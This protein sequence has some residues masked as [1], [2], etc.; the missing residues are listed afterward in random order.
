MLHYHLTWLWYAVAV[1]MLVDA[2]ACTVGAITRSGALSPPKSLI[3][4]SGCY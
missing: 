1:L 3:G 2:V 4:K